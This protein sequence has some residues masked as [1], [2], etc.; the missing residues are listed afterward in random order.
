MWVEKNRKRDLDN[1]AAG[2]RKLI[3]DSLVD[4]GVLKNDGWK[5]VEGWTDSFSINKDRP[6]VWVE[7]IGG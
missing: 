6:G 4:I 3:L 2:G 7:I 5:N 1:I